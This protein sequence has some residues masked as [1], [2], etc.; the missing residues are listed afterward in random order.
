MKPLLFLL[1]IFLIGCGGGYCPT[2]GGCGNKPHAQV[3]GICLSC[4]SESENGTDVL[5]KACAKHQNRCI[6]CGGD[7]R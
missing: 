7:L 6:H 5:C 4:R 1:L 3:R 2:C